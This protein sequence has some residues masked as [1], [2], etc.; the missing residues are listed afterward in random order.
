MSKNIFIFKNVERAKNFKKK[1][2][3]LH[4]YGRAC[5]SRHPTFLV[6]EFKLFG[7]NLL[8]LPITSII[9]GEKKN[10]YRKYNANPG[11]RVFHGFRNFVG[12]LPYE[13]LELQ[14]FD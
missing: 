7:Q 9:L 14:C 2:R 12:S 6:V 8:Y 13:E 4:A 11:T 5:V 3:G 10:K 1:Y